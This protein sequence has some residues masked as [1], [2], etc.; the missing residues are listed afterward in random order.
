MRVKNKMSD[1]D[2]SESKNDLTYWEIINFL[3]QSVKEK[4]ITD[5]SVLIF[6]TMIRDNK[7]V[8]TY[9]RS[10]KNHFDKFESFE[11]Y[12]K[13]M[14]LMKND[15]EWK[16]YIHTNVRSLFGYFELQSDPIKVIKQ[17]ISDALEREGK[18]CDF[19]DSI[20]PQ[21]K[22]GQCQ[23]EYHEG[24]RIEEKIFLTL[25]PDNETSKFIDDSGEYICQTCLDNLDGSD[26]EVS[27]DME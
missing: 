18:I 8:S 17:L 25:Y 23:S 22:F 15:R 7:Y 20:N 1:E 10:L 16:H 3:E 21:E 14:E 13:E 11:D 9:I 5:E 6:K 26:C 12:K 27:C 2:K 4:K 24:D 19:R